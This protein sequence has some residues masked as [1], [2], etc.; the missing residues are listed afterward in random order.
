[1]SSAPRQYAEPVAPTAPRPTMRLTS[2]RLRPTIGQVQTLGRFHASQAAGRSPHQHDMSV[3][4]SVGHVCLYAE[5]C[6][7]YDAGWLAIGG[8]DRSYLRITESGVR[9]LHAAEA[10]YLEASS[11]VE[12][13]PVNDEH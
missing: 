2:D 7:L 11:A 3:V 13:A 10:E 6:E 5:A 4:D 12:L 8:A 1:M 9:E